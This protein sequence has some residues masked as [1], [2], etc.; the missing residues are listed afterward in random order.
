MSSNTAA[1]F[2]PKAKSAT[3]WASRKTSSRAAVTGF[4]TGSG[5]VAV[6]VDFSDEFSLARQV[7]ETRPN[8]GDL[9]TARA[10]ENIIWWSNQAVR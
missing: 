2:W 6:I 3:G 5:R 8:A 7:T 1:T 4:N 9:T 10:R